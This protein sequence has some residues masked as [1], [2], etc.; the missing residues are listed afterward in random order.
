MDPFIQEKLLDLLVNIVSI[1]LGGGIILLIIELSRH[2]REKRVWAREDQ[3]LEIDIPRADLRVI[4]WQITAE[5]RDADK[6]VIYEHK[7]E[8]TVRQLLIAANFV[9][10]NTTGAEIIVTSYDANV[11]QIPPG[12]DRKG[13]YDLETFDLIS[14]EEIGTI[15]LQPFAAIARMVILEADFSSERRLDTAPSTLVVEAK[16]SSGATI[17]GKAAL[18]IVPRLPDIDLGMHEEN[19]YHHYPKQYLKKLEE[20]PEEEEG[21]EELPF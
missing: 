11:L 1:I 5:M 4:K 15:K 14:V 2:R 13:F 3:L 10:R 21:E 8:G 7:L 6:V 17:H 19:Y 9:I 18:T 16:T 20:E 12:H